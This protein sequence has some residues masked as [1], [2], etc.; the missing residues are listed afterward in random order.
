V[1]ITVNILSQ[2]L[3]VAYK[4]LSRNRAAA[5][6]GHKNTLPELTCSVIVMP[7]VKTGGNKLQDAY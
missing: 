6:A 3:E 2:G 7:S 5:V 4:A 1:Q